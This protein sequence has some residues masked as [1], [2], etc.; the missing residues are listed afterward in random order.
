MCILRGVPCELIE[1]LGI[2]SV[3]LMLSCVP[4]YVRS[5][6][7]YTLT[8]IEKNEMIKVLTDGP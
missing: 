4:S 6:T 3:L 7:V 1:W 8:T 2:F 5:G